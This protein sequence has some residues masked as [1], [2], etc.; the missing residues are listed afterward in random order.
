MLHKDGLHHGLNLFFI[1]NSDFC[2]DQPPI[3]NTVAVNFS[4]YILSRV[5]WFIKTVKTMVLIILDPNL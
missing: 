4:Y 1:D 5:V 2:P 3:Y